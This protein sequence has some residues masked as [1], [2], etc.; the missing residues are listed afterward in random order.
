MAHLLGADAGEP[1]GDGHAT[2][3]TSVVEEGASSDVHFG[4]LRVKDAM[5]SDH[6][7]V[8]AAAKFGENTSLGGTLF[9]VPSDSLESP[10]MPATAGAVSALGEPTSLEIEG[11]G[12]EV[13]D[14]L[15]VD[16]TSGDPTGAGIMFDA[17]NSW[18]EATAL[19]L[20]LA[21]A[22]REAVDGPTQHEGAELDDEEA[23]AEE[24][25]A[26]SFR[27]SKTWIEPSDADA[28]KRLPPPEQSMLSVLIFFSCSEKAA[29]T[30]LGRAEVGRGGGAAAVAAA[31]ETFFAGGAARPPAAAEL[32]APPATLPIPVPV[33]CFFVVPALSKK[34]VIAWP[35]G[36]GGFFLLAP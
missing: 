31:A 12:V 21:E 18:P 24:L 30:H 10:Y 1:A 5:L 28:A 2:G 22:L 3:Y 29:T 16:F 35:A 11:C 26:R 33:P 7:V 32:E 15:V 36:G 23:D 34:R 9:F 20:V 19:H 6:E 13:L 27:R 8:L 25:P 4:F 17:S 14:S